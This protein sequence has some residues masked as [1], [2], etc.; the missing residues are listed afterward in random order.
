MRKHVSQTEQGASGVG[1]R[2]TYI[3][4]VTS[5]ILVTLAGCSPNRTVFSP[6]QDEL[7]APQRE[8]M[9]VGEWVW[10]G[11]ITMEDGVYH[12]AEA[13]LYTSFDTSGAAE[14]S[15]AVMSERTT[16]RWDVTD[17][18]RLH[19]TSGASDGLYRFFF[20]NGMLYLESDS[21]WAEYRREQ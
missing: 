13:P 18:G 12:S 4:I 16:E 6:T 8:S 7:N 21:S 19:L 17:D 11:S 20:R 2:F 10:V 15:P 5:V 9:L 1:R 14:T 3:V